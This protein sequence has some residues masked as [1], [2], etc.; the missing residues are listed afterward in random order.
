MV[1]LMMEL[2]TFIRNPS[3]QMRYQRAQDHHDQD[4][5][6]NTL[7]TLK[8]ARVAMLTAIDKVAV[9]IDADSLQDSRR[10]PE[11]AITKE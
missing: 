4:H 9:L 7:K 8:E 1:D 10:A 6:V 3:P 5:R 2:L 11:Q